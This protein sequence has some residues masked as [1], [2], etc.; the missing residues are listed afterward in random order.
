MKIFRRFRESL[1]PAKGFRKYVLYALGEIILVVVGILIA[2]AVNNKNID[3]LKHQKTLKVAEKVLAQLKIDTFE[4]K[5][6]FREWD[7]IEESIDTVLVHTKM[8]APIENCISCRSL[9]IKFRIPNVDNSVVDFIK[10]EEIENTPVGNAL[11]NIREQYR[12][13]NTVN[14]L[15]G[16]VAVNTL[17]ENLNYLKD[18]FDWFAQFVTQGICNS[19][20]KDYFDNSTDFRNR[21]ALAYLL[22]Y[23]SYYGDL[24]EFISDLESDISTLESL[25]EDARAG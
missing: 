1:I 14:E 17:N 24:D 18:N 9:I 7:I 20:C 3:Y 21:V 10:T 15:Y 6:V 19:G 5:S 4:I 12:G 11:L 22:I 23:N 2:L 13:F 8:G 16:T 25:V